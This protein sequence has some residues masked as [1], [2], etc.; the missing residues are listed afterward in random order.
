MVTIQHHINP[1]IVLAAS[2]FKIKPTKAIDPDR[3]VKGIFARLFYYMLT[4][5]TVPKWQ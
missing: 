2:L 3:E 4:T 5:H 1:H